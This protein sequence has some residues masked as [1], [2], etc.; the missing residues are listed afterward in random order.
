MILSIIEL[1]PSPGKREKVLELLRFCIDRLSTKGGCLDAAVYQASNQDGTILYL[2]R[3][4]SSEDFR[5]YV[6]SD[7]YLGILAAIDLAKELPKINFLE[8]SNMKS[9]ELIVALRSGG[10]STSL[11]RPKP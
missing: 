4:D 9:L 11:E 3:W 10:P 1:T 7:F 8:V 2:E 6:Q 5:R